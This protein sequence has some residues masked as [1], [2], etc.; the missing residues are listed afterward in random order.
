MKNLCINCAHHRHSDRKA[1]SGERCAHP[2]VINPVRGED[3]SCYVTRSRDGACGAEGMLFSD[4]SKVLFADR[5]KNKCGG[6]Q[7]SDKVC[8]NMSKKPKSSLMC[9]PLATLIAEEVGVCVIW[10]SVN[11]QKLSQDS[12]LSDSETETRPNKDWLYVVYR[13][14]DGSV[15]LTIY[16]GDVSADIALSPEMAEQMARAITGRDL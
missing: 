4:R 6:E 5:V 14:A 3:A 7:A 13:D 16:D 10:P 11:N 8:V 9:V 2:E 15:A 1:E 12:R